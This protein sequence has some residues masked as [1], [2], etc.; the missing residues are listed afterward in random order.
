MQMNYDAARHD[1]SHIIFKIAKNALLKMQN[2]TY[3]TKSRIFDEL[4]Y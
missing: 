4:Y 1:I 2:T 3:K